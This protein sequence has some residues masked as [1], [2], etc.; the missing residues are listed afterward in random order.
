V[1]EASAGT[2]QVY[3]YNPKER[4][5]ETSLSAY[6]KTHTPLIGRVTKRGGSNDLDLAL[7]RLPA[8]TAGYPTVEIGD[9]DAV[10]IGQDVV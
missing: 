3:L 6:V 5:L 10:R 8:L 2:V 4:S 7:V 1:V 9:S